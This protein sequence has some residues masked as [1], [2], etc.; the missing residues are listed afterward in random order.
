MK[1]I[2]FVLLFSLLVVVS[3][4]EVYVEDGK[5]IFEYENETAD[6]VFL[7]GTFNNWST[8]AWEMEYIDGVWIYVADDLQPGVYEYK[9]VVN[10][11]DWYEDP[12]SPDY[13]PDPYGGRNSSFELVLVNGELQIA[14]PAAEAAAEKTSIISGEY[15]F[16]LKAKLEEETGF[17]SDPVVS[18][19]VILS[20]NPDIENTDLELKIGASSS[21]YQF[22]VY[23]MKALWLQDMYSFGAF[24]KT[25]VNSKYN[26]DYENPEESLAG[27]AIFLN[28]NNFNVGLDLFSQNDK[29]KSGIFGSYSTDKYAL[30]ALFDTVDATSLV[31]RADA[32]GLY[33]EVDLED[34]EFDKVSVGYEK[35]DTFS[36]KLKYSNSNK[37]VTA[38]AIAN[39]QSFDLDAAVYYEMEEG[40][41]Y[42]LKVGGGYEFLESFRIGGD[43]YYN[44]DENFGYDVNFKAANEEMPVELMLLFGNIID[45]ADLATFNEDKYLSI[46]MVAE[47]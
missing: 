10:G 40:N 38:E 6:T 44:A 32:Y 8:T 18:N 34:F 28:W 9:Y 46:S 14:A 31:V 13:V 29:F 42:A 35:E 33:G 47:F 2:V 7:A 26:F 45:T 27:F 3:F 1:K 25:E 17:L 36:V 22:K 20:I 39:Y 19:E 16:N 5:V 41:F 24:Y 4:S 11:T 43:V 30:S 21:N 12:E 15:E 23:G 37:D